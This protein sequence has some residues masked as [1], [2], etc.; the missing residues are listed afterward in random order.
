MNNFHYNYIKNKY[1]DKADL[2]FTDSDN[3]MN[4]IKTENVYEDF[5]IDRK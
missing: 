4:K 5:G 3:L 1:D 2:M